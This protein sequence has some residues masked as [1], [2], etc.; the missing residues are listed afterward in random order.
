MGQA[1]DDGRLSKSPLPRRPGLPAVEARDMEI[2]TVD[3]VHR[4]ADAIDPRYRTMV[5][6]AA[7]TG[8]RPGETAG[9][10]IETIDLLRCSITVAAT[11]FR[12]FA[13]RSALARRKRN[14]QRVLWPSLARWRER[15]GFTSAATPARTA[16]SLPR[17]KRWTAS[18]DQPS[19]GG[20]WLPA[21]DAANIEPLVFHDLRHTHAAWLI[22]A[23]GAPQSH[24]LNG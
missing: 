4:L 3:E 7:Y 21:L 6:T 9:L 22:A 12:R 11:A 13:A 17:S 8:L 1:V 2:L 19:D 14:A 10:K 5:L 24:L 16:G 18:S 15:L 23:R 20:C